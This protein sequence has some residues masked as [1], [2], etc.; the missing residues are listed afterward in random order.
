MNASWAEKHI[1]PL[2][3]RRIAVFVRNRR[4][5]ISLAIF[6]FLF[7]LTLFAEVLANDKP[8]LLSYKGELYFPLF[9][10]YSD[11]EFGG[12]FP[13]PADYKDKMILENIKKDGW[14]VWPPIRFSFNTVDYDL[15]VPT[16]SV[17]SWRHWLGTDDEGRDI[18]VR[19]YM[20]CGC[21]SYFAFLLTVV[22]SV[23]GIFAGLCKGISAES[24]IYLCSAFWK[25]GNLCRSC[26]F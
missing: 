24:W 9:R 17:P 20:G 18:L 26:L 6:L 3:L 5:V 7:V 8:L 11:A 15:E 19:I 16:P 12:D 10:T 1:S 23:I 13:T 21:L 14:A 4:A 2:N 25:F 22:S